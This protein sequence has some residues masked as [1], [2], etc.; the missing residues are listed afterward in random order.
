[1][2]M[3]LVVAIFLGGI[4]G[5]E[6]EFIG[7]EAGIRT[8]MLVAAGAAIFAM[9]GVNLPFLM[10]QAGLTDVAAGANGAMNLIANIVLGIGFLGG[11]IIFRE[12]EQSRD[13]VHGLTTAAVIWTTAGL[14][15][16][17]G[18]GLSEFAVF[19][20][21]FLAILLYILRQFSIHAENRQIPLYVPLPP[22][23]RLAKQGRA[24][25]S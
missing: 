2:I 18:A 4:M 13:R 3:R 21:I 19:S 1:M 24:K 23:K 25:K 14:G 22:K 12:R 8:S 20:T 5:W 10:I 11:G 17:A 6:R 15:A 16:L 9:L 7:K